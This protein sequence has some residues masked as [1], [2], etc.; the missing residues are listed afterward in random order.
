MDV[1]FLLVAVGA[2]RGLGPFD[3]E[4][5]LVEGDVAGTELHQDSGLPAPE[6]P[7][8]PH[9]SSR[10]EGIVDPVDVLETRGSSPS[11][12]PLRYGIGEEVDW[13]VLWCAGRS[14][15]HDF[16]EYVGP[17]V[18]TEADVARGPVHLQVNY[19]SGSVDPSPARAER[20]PPAGCLRE[21]VDLMV[22]VLRHR[23]DLVE[24]VVGWVGALV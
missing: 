16:G 10:W 19:A 14:L 23:V 17:L 3:T 8:Q 5:V 24:E 18:R 15:G 1:S 13:K 6:V 7:D 20:C 11:A 22:Q 2:D 4:E 21:P 12:L 9:V